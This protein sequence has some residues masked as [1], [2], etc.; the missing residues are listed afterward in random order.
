MR[1]PTPLNL[2]WSK[3]APWGFISAIYYK[4]GEYLAVGLGSLL[5]GSYGQEK[6]DCYEKQVCM[7]H[8]RLGTDD[9]VAPNLMCMLN[10]HSTCSRAHGA[11]GAACA[12]LRSCGR[13][14]VVCFTLQ[15]LPEIASGSL[16]MEQR[17]LRK[18]GWCNLSFLISCMQLML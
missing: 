14:L 4:S 6:G 1:N 18:L 17:L 10:S 11:P 5:Q 9:V 7:L 13:A 2:V 3:R 8:V 16:I 12:P 15:F